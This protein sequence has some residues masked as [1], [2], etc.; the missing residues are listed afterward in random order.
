M[1]FTVL[2]GTI[3]MRG[4]MSTSSR[5][6]ARGT[7]VA[8]QATLFR[9]TRMV[10]FWVHS[11]VLEGFDKH[12]ET[13]GDEGTQDGTEP[14]YPMVTFK[15]AGNNAGPKRTRWVKT[16]TSVVYSPML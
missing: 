3:L 4:R 2:L 16:A 5:Q 15:F 10:L 11:L 6:R 13:T 1:V 8:I 12:V 7:F 14:I 9:R